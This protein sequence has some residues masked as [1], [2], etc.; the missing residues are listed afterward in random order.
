MTEN[1]KA[2][3]ARLRRMGERV[4][5]SCPDNKAGCLV[6]H[7]R[8]ETDPTCAEAADRIEELES[9]KAAEDA[10]HHMLRAENGRLREVLREVTPPP[11][12]GEDEQSKAWWSKARAALGETQ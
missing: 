3:V 8:I 5:I 1:D 11:H 9:W 7:Y 2:L 10:H 12:F 6:Y 4:P